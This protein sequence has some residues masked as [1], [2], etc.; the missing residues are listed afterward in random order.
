MLSDI[1]ENQTYTS[2]GNQLF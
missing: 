2:R 1:M